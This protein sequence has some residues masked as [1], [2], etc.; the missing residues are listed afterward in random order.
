MAAPESYGA[1]YVHDLTQDLR[2]YEQS[3]S[4]MNAHHHQPG[5]H[6][7]VLTLNL[8]GSSISLML[9]WGWLARRLFALSL[10]QDDRSIG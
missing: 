3:D 8:A 7:R 1:D 10:G 6:E 5:S 2:H 9:R 4:T